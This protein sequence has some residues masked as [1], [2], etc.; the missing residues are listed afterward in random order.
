MKY[1]E[2]NALKVP[3]H[4]YNLIPILEKGEELSF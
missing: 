2:G 4:S 3:G 1:K